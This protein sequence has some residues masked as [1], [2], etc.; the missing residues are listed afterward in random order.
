MPVSE[1]A[2][3]E[4][5]PTA[6]AAD[7]KPTAGAPGGWVFPGFIL[8]INSAEY[9]YRVEFDFPGLGVQTVKDGD[10]APQKDPLKIPLDVLMK[11][12]VHVPSAGVTE[13]PL[14]RRQTTSIQ[15]VEQ[16]RTAFTGGQNVMSAELMTH[17]NDRLNS[18]RVTLDNFFEV[19]E[20][21][22]KSC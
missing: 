13:R 5:P 11:E 19:V 21:V 20:Q 7:T 6:I 12:R 3:H 16:T 15:T 2:P 18:S 10:L 17:A 14:V 9:S 22:A 4:S 8:G 1:P